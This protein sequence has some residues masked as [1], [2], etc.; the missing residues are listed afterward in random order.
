MIVIVQIMR[1]KVR[2]YSI[3]SQ[4]DDFRCPKF[5]FSSHVSIY[6]IIM[7]FFLCV[8]WLLWLWCCS[9][10]AWGR[11]SGSCSCSCLCASDVSTQSPKPET[12]AVNNKT[13]PVHHPCAKHAF[14]RDDGCVPGAV[15]P[16]M[17]LQTRS[18][19]VWVC[20]REC[21]DPVRLDSVMLRASIRAN[22]KAAT[23]IPG[24]PRIWR[25]PI[26]IHDGSDRGRFSEP[27]CDEW[28]EE[29]Q[30]QGSDWADTYELT[31]IQLKMDEET[32]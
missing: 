25:V 24:F 21:L 31:H 1:K 9:A 4:N 28:I 2:N 32:P 22:A 16:L 19:W 26:D 7:I 20:V 17:R 29:E 10:Q 6:I 3:K 12:E 23:V 27:R 14:I 8:L 13:Q 30:I 18:R 5:D 11:G 15:V